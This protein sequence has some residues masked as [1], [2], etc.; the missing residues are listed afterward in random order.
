MVDDAAPSWASSA[1]AQ[2]PTSR[3]GAALCLAQL[4]DLCVQV[5]SVEG[6]LDAGVRY[7]D[8]RSAHMENG[9][10]RNLHFVHMVYTTALVEVRAQCRQGRQPGTAMGGPGSRG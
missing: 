5:L 2:P 9:S 3:G 1:R 4:T 6:Q 7:L 8:L 10:E